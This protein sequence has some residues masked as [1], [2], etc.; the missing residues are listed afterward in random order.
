[1]KLH[2]A[3]CEGRIVDD[4]GNSGK[5]KRNPDDQVWSKHRE[6]EDD[7]EQIYQELKEKHD[8]KY[9]VRKLRLWARMIC[10]SI[11]S[12]KDDPPNIPAFHG[13]VAKKSRQQSASFSEAIT[14]AAVAITK[15]L[16]GTSTSE[17]ATESAIATPHDPVGK[18]SPGKVVDLRMKLYLE[19]LKYVKEL[20]EN[21]ILTEEE[22][23]EQKEIILSAMRE[24]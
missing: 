21:N 14:G 15:A 20:L 1:M 13:C 23:I 16:N 24:L 7:V 4:H 18:N 2:S 11:H 17:S 19:Q 10:A 3:W 8:D 22:F 9:E 5:R 6:R 12:S